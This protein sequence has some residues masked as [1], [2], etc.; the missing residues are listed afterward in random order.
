MLPGDDG[1]HGW[2]EL[3]LEASGVATW[4]DCSS[5]STEELLP[6]L[7]AISASGFIWSWALAVD[8]FR[9]VVR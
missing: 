9:R 3:L 7:E 8:R 2:G 1:M 5:K 6:L 4:A